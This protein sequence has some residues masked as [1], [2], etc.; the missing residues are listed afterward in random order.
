MLETLMIKNL[1]LSANLLNTDCQDSD[2]ML[3]IEEKISMNGFEV[4]KQW[5]GSRCKNQFLDYRDF[6]HLFFFHSGHN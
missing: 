4:E 3:R 6:I 1:D 2:E 5:L